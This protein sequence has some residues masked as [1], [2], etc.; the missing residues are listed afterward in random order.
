MKMTATPFRKRVLI[1]LIT[2]SSFVAMS[3]S[4]IAV[5]IAPQRNV[6]YW[7]DWTFL[8]I[9]KTQWGNIHILTGALFLIAGICHICCN[10][11]SLAQYLKGIPGCMTAGWRELTIAVLITAVF[12]VGAITKAPPFNY[13][14][15]VNAWVK[16]SWVGTP[17]D[18]PP[19]SGAE[20]LSLKDFCAKMSIES[21]A[22]LRELRQAGLAVYDEKTTV[23][24]I[25]RANRMSPSM[26]YLIIRKLE[27]PGVARPSS[28]V[29]KPSRITQ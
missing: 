7:T 28:F 10:R 16:G 3:L 14:L 12:S 24:H 22:A 20:L 27:R 29:P 5:F 9:S 8:E 2:A 1:S 26:V 21:G 23:A 13:I 11:T 15:Y 4:G 17:A 18:G 19:F 25:A 6:A